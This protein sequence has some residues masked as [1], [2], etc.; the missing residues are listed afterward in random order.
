M[1][2]REKKEI[3]KQNGLEY[4]AN[5][6]EIVKIYTESNKIELEDKESEN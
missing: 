1:E 3:E 2:G 5:E 4:K 6:R